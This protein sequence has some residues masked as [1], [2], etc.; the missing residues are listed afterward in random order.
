MSKKGKPFVHGMGKTK[1][2][3][4]WAGMKKR[5]L[6]K[7]CKDYLHYGGRGITVCDRWKNSFL[8]FLSDM[9]L[10][11]EGLTLD[12]KDNNGNYEPSNCIWATRKSQANNT[13]R[14]AFIE[15]N[16][17]TKT[18]SG[19]A[20]FLG[21]DHRVLHFRLKHWTLED[22]LT[23]PKTVRPYLINGKTYLEWSVILK[24]S[25]NAL[26]LRKSLKGTIFLEKDEIK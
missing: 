20:D 16:G 5:C 4:S 17:E 21:L 18:I 12:R 6:N 9:G 26:Y 22:A 23:K 24:V 3:Q 19:W 8:N 7:N 13:R 25:V 10:C 11:P 1:T 15:F 14:N 2:Y